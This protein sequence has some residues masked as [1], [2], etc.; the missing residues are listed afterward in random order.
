[1][2]LELIVLTHRFAVKHEK[3]KLGA[4]RGLAPT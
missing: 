4:L 1:M 2:S 3:G